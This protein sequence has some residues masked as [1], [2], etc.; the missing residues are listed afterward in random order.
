MAGCLHQWLSCYHRDQVQGQ[1][2]LLLFTCDAAKQLTGL[3]P[4]LSKEPQACINGGEGAHR[5]LAA[6]EV[7][8]DRVQAKQQ[9]AVTSGNAGAAVRLCHRSAR[10]SRRS[11]A[12]VPRSGRAPPQRACRRHRSHSRA[13]P[14]K[15]AAQRP[16]RGH[17]S[18]IR[19]GAAN[20]TEHKWPRG[21]RRRGGSW[22][23]RSP[24]RQWRW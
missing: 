22:G 17:L 15:H 14:P 7:T 5:A 16:A 13:R 2:A 11:S 1:C 12:A 23:V 3:Q 6:S 21:R 19:A 4:Y 24:C 20:R 18:H 9:L 10:C 8:A